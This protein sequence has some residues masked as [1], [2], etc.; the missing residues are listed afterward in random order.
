MLCPK[1]GLQA[2]VIWAFSVAPY[3]KLVEASGSLQGTGDAQ[4]SR[5]LKILTGITACAVPVTR[6]CAMHG[7]SMH[8][9]S[10]HD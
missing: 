6:R 9:S 3:S 5:T 4:K 7:S 2:L 10:V 1:L 8:D